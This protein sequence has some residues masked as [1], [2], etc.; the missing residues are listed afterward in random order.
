MPVD[1]AALEFV[2][3][4][5]R[6]K[7]PEA[8]PIDA[9]T[10]LV[11]SRL[12]DS[13][14]FIEF[15][16]A[17]EER[18]EREILLEDVAPEDFRTI[19]S[20]ELRFFATPSRSNAGPVA[21]SPMTSESDAVSTVQETD[22]EYVRTY[23]LDNADP[24]ERQRLAELEEAWDPG[25]RS[26]FERL[27]LSEGHN[28]LMVAGGGGSL[29]EWV[30][31][32]VGPTGSVSATDLDPRFLLGL[33]ER[34][35]SLSVERHNIVTDDLAQ[36]AYDFVHT[37]L[38]VAHLPERQAVIEKMAAA[39]KPGGWL[40]IEDFDS[41]SR[42]PAYPNDLAERA[43]RANYELL[44]HAGYDPF[45]GRRLPTMMRKIGLTD[46]DAFGTTLSLRGSATTLA[47]WYQK[48]FLRY[49][50]RLVALGGITA[51]EVDAFAR[52][53]DD[54]EFDMLAHTMMSVWGRRP[55]GR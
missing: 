36:D 16:M 24:E 23:T 31:R 3:G 51:D 15:L 27:G 11:A 47:S 34:H 42:G 37:R 46:V 29:V 54:P 6:R 48:T 7:H 2:D 49:R 50:E 14:D 39:V 22:P 45:T 9:D 30:T 21:Q 44:A 5:V 20:I 19:R 52:Q 4:F 33:A 1:S 25:T 40:L 53:Y 43:L 55:S 12:L 10:D 26:H 17:L 13:L 35:P 38:L 32:A 41:G 18:T 8:Q 28:V